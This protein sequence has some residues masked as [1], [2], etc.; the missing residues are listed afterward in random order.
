MLNIDNFLHNSVKC[1][2]ITK[3]MHTILEF[4]EIKIEDYDQNIVTPPNKKYPIQSN[5]WMVF[6]KI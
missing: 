5:M 2:K 3:R 1:S 6:T 4:F